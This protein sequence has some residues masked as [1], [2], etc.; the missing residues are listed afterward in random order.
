MTKRW[1]IAALAVAASTAAAA[2]PDLTGRKLVFDD[3][4]NG[5]SVDW[6][7]WRGDSSSQGYCGRGNPTN[8]QIGYA[9]DARSTVSGG[10]LS[11]NALRGSV[12]QCGRTWPWTNARL[13]GGPSM[14]EGYIEVRAKPPKE[15]GF[16]SSF[17]TWVYPGRE[18]LGTQ[19]RDPYEQYSSSQQWVH[20]GGGE[21]GEGLPWQADNPQNTNPGPFDPTAGFHVYGADIKLDGTDFYV[22]GVLKFHSPPGS[23]PLVAWNIIV[24]IAVCDSN[25]GGPPP[26]G[27]NS[28][29]HVIDYV[30]AWSSDAGLPAVTPEPGY[31]GPPV[32]GGGGG[33]ST[34][35]LVCTVTAPCSGSFATEVK[36]NRDGTFVAQ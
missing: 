18:S 1:M 32:G 9:L 30:R 29:A 20:F 14:R 21:G 4:F 8:Q 27:V 12:T 7:R 34:T 22:D 24:D 15:D 3:E 31:D 25:C 2:G 16:R 5:T 28:A 10:F 35:G 6:T 36:V 17:W 23:N 26:T 19:E 13:Q 11:L 33:G